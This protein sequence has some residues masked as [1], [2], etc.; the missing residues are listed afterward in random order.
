[1]TPVDQNPFLSMKAWTTCIICSSLSYFAFFLCIAAIWVLLSF[2]IRIWRFRVGIPCRVPV[3]VLQD[4]SS[5]TPPL[6]TPLTPSS[7][8]A[9][10]PGKHRAKPWDAI[11]SNLGRFTRPLLLLIRTPADPKAMVLWVYPHPCS[12]FGLWVCGYSLSLS[13]SFQNH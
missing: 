5:S 4:F 2:L 9:D 1:M 13:F 6:V 7:L 10:S 12:L 8:S 3:L 11:S